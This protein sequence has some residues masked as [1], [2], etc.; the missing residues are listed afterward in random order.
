MKKT[1]LFITGNENKLREAREILSEEK[2]I[3][4]NI[5]LP[6]LQ[7]EPIKIVEEKTKLAVKMLKKPVIVDDTNLRFNA[8]NGL[9]G[10]YIKDFLHGLGREGLYK[11]LT[12]FEDKS[13]EAVAL[14]GYGELGTEVK[15]FEG[16]VSGTIVN[17]RGESNFGWDSIFLPDGH[18]KTYAEMNAE[19]KN[20][21]SHRRKA[22]L[23]LRKYLEGE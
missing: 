9:P 20:K 7:E 11:L 13:A 14:I 23:K 17:P 12:G 21:I 16:K 2:I 18:D 5:D 19:E 1:I 10:P 15:V 4:E 8:L 6:E 22:L 3:N